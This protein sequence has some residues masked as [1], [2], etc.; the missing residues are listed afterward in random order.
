MSLVDIQLDLFIRLVKLAGLASLL[1]R[2]DRLLK[3]L[4]DLEAALP[5][6]ALDV[7]LDTPVRGNCDFKFAL[8]HI[9]NHPNA[10]P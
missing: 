10:G 9:V 4:H 1:K 2:T 5:F 6:V 3:N 8:W 7:E